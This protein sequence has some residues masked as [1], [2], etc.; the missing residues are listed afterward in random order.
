M[1]RGKVFREIDERLRKYHIVVDDHLAED[2]SEMEFT[3]P[4][5][6]NT[7]VHVGA[8][9]GTIVEDRTVLGGITFRPKDFQKLWTAFRNATRGGAPAFHYHALSA[10][11]MYQQVY[12]YILDANPLEISYA[13]TETKMPG[14]KASK[15]WGF[16]EITDIV[17]KLD[18]RPLSM[19]AIR[20][21]RRIGARLGLAPVR[22]VDI[23]SL[24]A[25]LT[26]DA[27]N[28][29]IDH[30]GFTVR[31]KDGV[32]IM[33]ADFLQHLAD[34]LI[35]KTYLRGVLGDWFTEHFSIIMPSSD[36]AYSPVTGLGFSLTKGPVTIGAA[37]TI[38]CRCLPNYRMDFGE[39]Q[40]N[41]N[42]GW[43]IGASL[44]IRHDLGK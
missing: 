23:T 16:R 17:P 9:Q 18:D 10:K 44:S 29:H 40:V 28:V 34:E 14:Q 39:R 5:F 6:P 36:N 13:A 22:V 12:R 33:T 3:A 30:V 27:C 1:P 2:A 11:P 31:G 8:R 20:P 25:A 24:H 7:K 4:G 26:P 32:P 41:L 42:K 15:A 38:G 21:D 35:L 37:A 43:S 19:D